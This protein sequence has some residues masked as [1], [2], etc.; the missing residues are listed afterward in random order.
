MGGKCTHLHRF[1]S[2]RRPC[3][4]IGPAH[5]RKPRWR[6][7]MRRHGPRRGRALI[8]TPREPD[9]AAGL[10]PM[11]AAGDRGESQGVEGHRVSGQRGASAITI[12]GWS[13][14]CVW[15]AAQSSQSRASTG[16]R[17]RGPARELG[18]QRAGVSE[19]CAETHPFRAKRLHFRGSCVRVH[20]S[21]ALS[22]LPTPSRGAEPQT[23]CSLVGQ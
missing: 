12:C 3:A 15:P 9:R 8:C 7:W 6:S 16:T 21:A 11:G 10:K 20:R 22:K 1:R 13:L 19:N 18:Q 5:R 2:A 17:S 23:G 4:C 14:H